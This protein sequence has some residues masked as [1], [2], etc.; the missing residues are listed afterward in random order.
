MH[1]EI[2]FPLVSVADAGGQVEHY[3]YSPEIMVFMDYRSHSVGADDGPFGDIPTFLYSMPVSSTRVFFEVDINSWKLVCAPMDVCTPLSCAILLSGASGQETCLAAR[4]AMPF[5]VLK[6]RL[7]TR[8]EKMGI[9]VTR[10]F[11]EVRD[12]LL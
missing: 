7:H 5:E 8:L 12:V 10:Q 6:E 3:P 9:K 11:E 4:P 1:G 2:A